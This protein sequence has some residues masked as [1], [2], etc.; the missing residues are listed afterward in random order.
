MFHHTAVR[1][2]ADNASVNKMSVRNIVRIFGPTVMTVD[3]DES[4]FVNANYEFCVV[5]SMFRQYHWMFQVCVRVFSL[6]IMYMY[7]L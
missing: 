1:R 2:V 6:C 5:E 4:T 3:S 7:I